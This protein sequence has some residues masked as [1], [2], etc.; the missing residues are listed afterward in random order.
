MGIV[1][2]RPTLRQL[3]TS[4]NI[5][6]VKICTDPNISFI[7][8]LKYQGYSYIY[9][10][11][12]YNQNKRLHYSILVTLM[13]VTSS[14]L[15]QIMLFSSFTPVEH[16][17]IQHIC[18][19]GFFPCGQFISVFFIIRLKYRWMPHQRAQVFFCQKLHYVMFI[20]NVKNN[21]GCLKR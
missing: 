7:V 1:V 3:R 11:L 2:F 20:N 6:Y 15:K 21:N 18:R 4:Q 16:H 9:I 12:G 13:D 14:L 17:F 19:W 10:N 8:S 5:L